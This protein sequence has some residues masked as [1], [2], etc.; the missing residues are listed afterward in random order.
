MLRQIVVLFLS[1][2]AFSKAYPMY[3]SFSSSGCAGTP[4][5]T[6][7]SG[8]CYYSKTTNVST[9]TSFT[10]CGKSSGTVLITYYD[11]AT[12]CD[13]NATRTS[14]KTLSWDESKCHDLTNTTSAKYICK[15]P[16]ATTNPGKV[17]KQTL[18]FTGLTKAQVDGKKT[19]IEAGIARALGVAAAD[20]TITSVTESESRRRNLLAK[21]V[22]ISYEVKVKDDSAATALVS[23]MKGS[24]FETATKTE[25]ATTLN[26]AE[27]S[28]TVSAKE[29]EVENADAKETKGDVSSAITSIPNIIATT[30]TLST[31]FYNAQF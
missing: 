1:L 8:V 9:M 29:P 13:G 18:E 26:V 4:T 11:D 15:A 6:G 28:I 10:D 24:D 12:T 21:K 20:V 14:T 5:F 16:A 31:I 23:K 27:D 3:Q 22:V 7:L 30:L 2:L 19:E 25:V 17:V